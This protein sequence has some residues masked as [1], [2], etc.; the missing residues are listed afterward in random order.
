M[1]MRRP[2]LLLLF[3]VLFLFRPAAARASDPTVAPVDFSLSCD[4]ADPAGQAFSAAIQTHLTKDAEFRLVGAQEA[5]RSGAMEIHITSTPLPP[6]N[7][8]ARVALSIVYT[9]GGRSMQQSIQICT[10]GPLNLSA[11][12]LVH[13]VK[14]LEAEPTDPQETSDILTA[15]LR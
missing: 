3:A 13:N 14:Q 6:A 5:H 1:P 12:V 15:S 11:A 8:I 9:H 7:G 10:H 4:C 2:A